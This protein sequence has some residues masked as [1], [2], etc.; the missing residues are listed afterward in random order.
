[1]IGLGFGM[2][3]PED[4]NAYVDPWWAYVATQGL[5][6]VHKAIFLRDKRVTFVAPIGSAFER[7]PDFVEA[8][9]ASGKPVVVS[10]HGLA[11]GSPVDDRICIFAGNCIKAGTASN[12]RST[13]ISPTIAK[14]LGL[15]GMNTDSIL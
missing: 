5:T 10:T 15:S 2:L 6:N 3:H 1:M 14:V 12:V 11:P 13:Q 9:V 7:R 4:T 8:N